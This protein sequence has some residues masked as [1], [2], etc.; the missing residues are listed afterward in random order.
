MT[1][2]RHEFPAGV[3]GEF[4]AVAGEGIVFASGGGDAGVFHVLCHEGA[5]VGNE[6]APLV[7]E[8][9]RGIDCANAF[10][11]DKVGIGEGELW[12]GEGKHDDGA[13]DESGFGQGDFFLAFSVTLLLPGF[14]FLAL[15]ALGTGFD[16]F[17]GEVG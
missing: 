15:V 5:V 2:P 17:G 3:E 11:G 1:F 4:P 10:E 8:R 12:L 13:I 16:F 9:N 14:E 7:A 6:A